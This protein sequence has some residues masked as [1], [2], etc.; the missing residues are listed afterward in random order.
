MESKEDLIQNPYFNAISK[1]KSL[2]SQNHSMISY[3]KEMHSLMNKS[4][5]KSSDNSSAIKFDNPFL[6]KTKTYIIN[7]K[8]NNSKIL[9][10]KSD[11]SFLVFTDNNTNI[12]SIS[13]EEWKSFTNLEKNV[14]SQNYLKKIKNINSNV[15][16]K[17]GS[18]DNS[19]IFN[20]SLKKLFSKSGFEIENKKFSDFEKENNFDF[21][22]D[23]DL[24][25]NLFIFND[26]IIL[27]IDSNK[28]G[29]SKNFPFNIFQDENKIL[30]I[31]TSK[32]STTSNK[33]IFSKENNN[34]K[35]MDDLKNFQKREIKEIINNYLK[36]YKNI[37]KINKIKIN[38][39]S[40]SVYF[41]KKNYILMCSLFLDNIQKKKMKIFKRE[42]FL[43]KNKNLV[44]SSIFVI[45]KNLNSKLVDLNKMKNFDKFKKLNNLFSMR[46][47]TIKK[48]LYSIKYGCFENLYI[49]KNENEGGEEKIA[50]LT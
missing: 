33:S 23:N 49:I 7:S 44:Q 22:N 4:S 1:D 30:D 21:K 48:I 27:S 46:I 45:K 15:E 50:L 31:F 36:K 32:K 14:F 28:I 41:I 24:K 8:S 20:L 17:T 42:N 19:N 37:F 13:N 40:L 26:E 39:L 29:T 38:D 35:N 5:Q 34:L 6:L 3:I 10:N 18:L 2:K 16:K 12:I 43:Q 47:K 25:N 11:S 9:N